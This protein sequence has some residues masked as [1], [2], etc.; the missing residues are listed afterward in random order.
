MVENTSWAV[1]SVVI[2]ERVMFTLPE[3]CHASGAERGDL[4]ALVH[5]GL[6]AP[7]GDGPE[8]WLFNGPALMQAR[9]ALRL[10]RELDIGL[11]GAAVVID[12]LD[13]IDSLRTLLRRRVAS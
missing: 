7:T 10:A 3:L 2:D 5:E 4:L 13:E 9:R 8:A 6:L 11:A 1:T 12:L